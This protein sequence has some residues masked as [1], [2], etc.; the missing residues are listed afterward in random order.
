MRART[1]QQGAL[2]APLDARAR[3]GQSAADERQKPAV[4][5][6]DPVRNRCN[7]GGQG[8][9]QRLGQRRGDQQAEGRARA[10]RKTA[11]AEALDVS[12]S[13]RCKRTALLARSA[14]CADAS[15]SASPPIRG[16]IRSRAAKAAT[17]NAT[18]TTA[19]SAATSRNPNVNCGAGYYSNTCQRRLAYRHGICLNCDAEHRVAALRLLSAPRR[20]ANTECRA[21]LSSCKAACE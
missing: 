15:A 11:A 16:A 20:D 3:A 17:T 2:R 4:P 1:A 5:A 7:F 10:G 19:I 14:A 18:S 6:G 12:Q 13:V 21:D 8:H 9:D